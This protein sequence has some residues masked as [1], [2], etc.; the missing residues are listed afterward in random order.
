MESLP[1][2]Q[3]V[4]TDLKKKCNNLKWESL[5]QLRSRK[6]AVGHNVGG[7][8]GG[9]GCRSV[10]MVRESRIKRCTRTWINMT[11]AEVR[12]GK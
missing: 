10:I 2:H 12:G 7:G 1:P 5:S 3:I 4:R 11:E 8:G 6:H 9:G